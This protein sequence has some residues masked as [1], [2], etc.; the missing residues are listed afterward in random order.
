MVKV[1]I[2]ILERKTNKEKKQI[3]LEADPIDMKK[4]EIGHVLGL[5]YQEG[6]MVSVDI[7]DESTN[8]PVKHI[9]FDCDACD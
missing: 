2:H 9:K 6:K 5:T 8:K 7:I 1:V 3:S 4:L